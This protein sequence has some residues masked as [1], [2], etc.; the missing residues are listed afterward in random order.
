MLD[1]FIFICKASSQRIHVTEPK[2]DESICGCL[3]LVTYKGFVNMQIELL[4]CSV[5]NPL[6]LFVNNMP[7]K[8]K[9][10]FFK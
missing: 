1:I 7:R 5:I 9:E 10:H 3:N 8:L 2:S 4:L 6:C